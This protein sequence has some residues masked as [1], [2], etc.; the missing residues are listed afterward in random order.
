MPHLFHEYI[1]GKQIT[2]ESISS[3]DNKPSS[4]TTNDH[5][6]FYVQNN[7]HQQRCISSDSL[8]TNKNEVKGKK[9]RKNF[10]KREMNQQSAIYLR[11]ILRSNKKPESSSRHKSSNLGFDPSHAHLY[12]P[13]DG[14]VLRARRVQAPNSRI[15][16]LCHIG[17]WISFS[18]SLHFQEKKLKRI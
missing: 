11:L 18:T 5:P 12:L 7:S 9:E 2:G 1:E 15:Q 16:Y 6:Q 3:K 14:K 13:V 4:F 17:L 8:N 10:R